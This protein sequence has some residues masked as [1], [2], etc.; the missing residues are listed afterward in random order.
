M[1]SLDIYLQGLGVVALAALCTWLLS[2]VRRN[3]A[4]VD[5]LW[6][7]M[8]VLAAWT[9]A[10]QASA[11]GPR[12][13][14]VLALVTVWALRLSV[15]ITVRNWG[16]GEDRRYQAIRARNQPHFQIKSLYLIFAFQALLAWIISLPL[17]GA[18]LNSGAAASAHSN[19]LGVLDMAGTALWLVGFSFEA[20]GD[21]QLARFKA[22][23]ANRGKVMDRG[24]WR[25][26]RHPNYFGDFSVWWGLYLIAAGAGAWWSIIGPIGMS[27]LLMRVS[28]VTLLEKDIGERRPQYADYIRRTNA[29]FP[30]PPRA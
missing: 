14:L 29:F 19:S 15:Y 13:L 12:A 5:S 9:Y 2:L 7:L 1:F 26:T 24:F 20:G 25:Y 17:L 6:S 27:V 8:F 11:W 3:V 22:D 30:G 28:G 4:I 21:W 16:H 23:P 10:V 18:I